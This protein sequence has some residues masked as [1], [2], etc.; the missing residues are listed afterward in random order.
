MALDDKKQPIVV[1]KIIKKG[2]HHGGAWKIA[3]ADFATAM[4]AFFLLLWILGFTDDTQK[5]AISEFFQNP[6]AFLG[7]SPTPAFEAGTGTSPSLIDFEGAIDMAPEQMAELDAETIEELAEQQ[8]KERLEALMQALEEAIERSQALE[9]F[10]DQLLLDITP[11]GLRIQIVDK[12]NRPMFDLGSAQLRGYSTAI[13]QELGG[14]INQVPNKISIT[15]HTD[16]R[17]FL[18]PNYSNWELSSDRANAARRALVSGGMDE[19][20]IGRVVGL[21]ST[22]LFDKANPENPINRRISIIVMTR[23]T[24]AAIQKESEAAVYELRD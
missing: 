17:P 18:R 5:A 22:V 7:A 8:E 13:L 21:A 15:G 20:K 12:E 19:A 6:S 1:K 11:E 3:F 10:K 4:M 9:P 23:E 14:L 2:G 16:A 24:E